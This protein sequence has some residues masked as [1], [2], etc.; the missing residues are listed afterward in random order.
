MHFS[1]DEWSTQS[2]V[3]LSNIFSLFIVKSDYVKR[4]RLYITSIFIPKVNNLT[5]LFRKH[6]SRN[7]SGCDPLKTGIENHFQ[8]SP[9]GESPLK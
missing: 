4:I 1:S 5:V 6:N 3:G 7:A 8:G 2:G 9:E